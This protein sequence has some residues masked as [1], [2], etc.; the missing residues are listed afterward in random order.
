MSFIEKADNTGKIL[1]AKK[2]KEK[3]SHGKTVESV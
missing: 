3:L 2:I 1:L